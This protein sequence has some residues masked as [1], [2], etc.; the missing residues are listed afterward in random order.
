MKL[1]RGMRS[2]LSQ[3]WFRLLGYGSNGRNL[4]VYPDD[5]FLVGYPK[6]GNT[7]LDFMVA[8]LLAQDVEDVDFFTIENYVADIYFNNARKLRALSHPRCLKSHEPYD[9]RYEKVVYIVRDP[10]DV[11]VSYYYHHLKLGMWSEQEGLG[12]FV[13]KFVDGNLD[14]FGSWGDHV[15][16]WLEKRDGDPDFLL[17]RYEELKRDTVRALQIIARHVGVDAIPD[18]LVSAVSWAS[19]ENMQKLESRAVERGHPSFRKVRRDIHFVR[20][21]IPGGWE[22]QLAPENRQ[23]I[24]DAW[25]DEMRRLGYL[26]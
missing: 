1:F 15:R 25:G 13:R 24:E 4:D 21:G 22:N 10:R 2:S 18:R 12:L 17:V 20:K 3:A 7:W 9:D 5:R 16:G 6:S 23:L 8:C 11:A 14:G 26:G 19:V